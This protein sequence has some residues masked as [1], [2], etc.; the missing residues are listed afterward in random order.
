MEALQCNQPATRS[1]LITPENGAISGAQCWFRLLA[2]CVLSIDNNQVGLVE[3]KFILLSSWITF[4]FATMASLFVSPL[5]NY[6]GGWEKRLTGIH[7][8]DYPTTGLLKYSSAEASTW[9][10]NIFMFFVHSKKSIHIP[11]PKISLSPIFQSCFF[12]VPDHQPNHCPQNM[13]QYVIIYLA[14]PPSKSSE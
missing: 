3:W 5:D 12:Q 10:T 4:I 2:D 8:M 13:N 11:L 6:R 9:N 14:I 1:R 7:R